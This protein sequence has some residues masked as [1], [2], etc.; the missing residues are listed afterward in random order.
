MTDPDTFADNWAKAQEDVYQKTLEDSDRFNEW[1][2]KNTDDLTQAIN[3][4]D[5]KS[6][7]PTSWGYTSADE[8]LAEYFEQ[9]FTM[10]DLAKLA[11]TIHL[12]QDWL[13]EFEAWY[14]DMIFE[15]GEME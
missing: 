10:T 1:C 2:D 14:R 8:I 11:V 5:F 6:T 13:P 4:G 3:K 7:F 12:R 9:K 15:Y